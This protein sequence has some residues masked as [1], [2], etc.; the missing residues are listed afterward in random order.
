[1]AKY[2]VEKGV[3]HPAHINIERSDPIKL[4]QGS[5]IKKKKQLQI[6]KNHQERPLSG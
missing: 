3:D 5:L 4:A 2:P 6:T 1:M